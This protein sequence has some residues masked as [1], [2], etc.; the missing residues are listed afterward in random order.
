ME[1]KFADYTLWM[2]LANDPSQTEEARQYYRARLESTVHTQMR[3]AFQSAAAQAP[4]A[5]AKKDTP[6]SRR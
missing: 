3:D 5:V 6:N 1:E 2:Q 4:L